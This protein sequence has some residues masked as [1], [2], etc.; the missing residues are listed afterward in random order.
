MAG[1][2]SSWSNLTAKDIIAGLDDTDSTSMVSKAQDKIDE[3]KGELNDKQTALN[4]TVTTVNDL[5]NKCDSALTEVNQILTNAANAG[6]YVVVIDDCVGETDFLNTISAAIN[7]D[8][9]EAPTINDSTYIGCFMQLVTGADTTE[10]ESKMTDLKK[11]YQS[12]IQ[13][14]F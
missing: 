7:A 12:E 11:I 4:N 6:A 10:L 3:T 13:S 14:K 2:Y 8:D 5:I 1:T 9:T